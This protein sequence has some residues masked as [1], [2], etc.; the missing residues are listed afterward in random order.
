MELQLLQAKIK[1]HF[2]YNNLS[3]INWIAMENGQEK[4]CEITNALSSFYRTALN[5]GKVMSTLETEIANAVAYMDLQILSHVQAESLAEGLRFTTHIQ[6]GFEKTALPC[7]IL[8]PLL[9]NAVEHG[10]DR[11]RGG[12][13]EIDLSVSEN[14]GI[15]RLVV[16]DNGDELYNALGP[17]TL[18]KSHYGYGLSNVDQRIRLLFGEPFGAWVKACPGGTSAGIILPLNGT[19][20]ARQRERQLVHPSSL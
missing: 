15:L 20:A 2:L 8:Q 18:D 10:T 9:E 17:S 1:P 16:R 14:D 11:L 3:A 6:N 13:G 12:G 19:E 7:F 4:I 5:Q